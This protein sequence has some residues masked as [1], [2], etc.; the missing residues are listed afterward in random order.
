MPLVAVARKLGWPPSRL[1]AWLRARG[2]DEEHPRQVEVAVLIGEGFNRSPGCVHGSC[3]EP[4]ASRE[5]WP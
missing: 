5:D 2:C 3:D 1:A 4:R